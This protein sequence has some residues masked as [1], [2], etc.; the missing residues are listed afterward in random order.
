M[1]TWAKIARTYLAGEDH[2]DPNA[3]SAC[4]AELCMIMEDIT[5]PNPTTLRQY[6]ISFLAG[7]NDLNSDY[8]V[9]EFLSIEYSTDNAASFTTLFCYTYTQNG[10]IEVLSEDANCAQPGDGVNILGPTM[11]SYA[12]TFTAINPTNNQIS[13]RVLCTFKFFW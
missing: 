6:Q 7:G 12:G 3:C 8:E 9:D 2:D 11:Q 1:I 13:I 10:A 4:T 5:V